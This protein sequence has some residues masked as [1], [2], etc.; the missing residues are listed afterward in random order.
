VISIGDGD[1]I[2][3]ASKVKLAA[4]SRKEIMVLKDGGYK[5]SGV[6]RTKA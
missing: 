2:G 4:S 5:T 1:N 3:N 6:Y